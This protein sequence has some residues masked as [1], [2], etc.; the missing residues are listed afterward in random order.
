MVP[1]GNEGGLSLKQFPPG[2]SRAAKKE[3]P[4][5]KRVGPESPRHRSGTVRGNWRIE[6]LI[7]KTHDSYDLNTTERMKPTAAYTDHLNGD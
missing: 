5:K 7:H 3:G 1:V 6:E 4:T 2:H